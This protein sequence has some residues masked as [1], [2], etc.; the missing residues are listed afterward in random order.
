MVSFSN[1]PL[2]TLPGVCWVGHEAAFLFAEYCST[3][4]E[5]GEMVATCVAESSR[6]NGRGVAVSG[7]C[8]EHKVPR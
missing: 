5:Q 1:D 7:L 3:A 4:G 2:A 8:R 6:D